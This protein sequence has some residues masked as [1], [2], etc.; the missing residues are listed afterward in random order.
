MS[1][2]FIFIVLFFASQNIQAWECVEVVDEMTGEPSGEKYV[3]A[4]SEN[5]L[6]GYV[7]SRIQTAERKD[8]TKAA[9]RYILKSPKIEVPGDF[10]P[11]VY[12]ENSVYLITQYGDEG[13]K[14]AWSDKSEFFGETYYQHVRVKFDNERA[15]HFILSLLPNN[16][17]GWLYPRGFTGFS[18]DEFKKGL[19]EHE[20][21]WVEVTPV[22]MTKAQIAKFSLVGFNEAFAECG[23]SL[24]PEKEKR[25]GGAPEV[26]KSG[27][28]F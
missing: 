16:E 6:T 22:G 4:Y 14:I 27:V 3:G 25:E 13:F 20:G 7:T 19:T 5:K 28:L 21:V 10:D 17:G 1:K 9:L 2:F 12:Y 8:T 23:G 18:E 24:K 15:R 11:K 26:D